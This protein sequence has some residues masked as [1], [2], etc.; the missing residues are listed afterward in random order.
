MEQEFIDLFSLKR[1]N[2]IKSTKTGEIYLNEKNECFFMESPI[3]AKQFC[4]LNEGTDLLEA[5]Y[6]KNIQVFVNTLYQQGVDAINIKLKNEKD[7]I[8]YKI[9]TEDLKKNGYCNH[10]VNQCLLQL[11]QTGYK[12]Y[13]R[14]LKDE[15]FLTPV[16]LIKR[17]EEQYPVIKYC[18]V[19]KDG[20]YYNILFSTLQEF[21]EWNEEQIS[22]YCP[23][24]V[25]ISKFERIRKN[26]S[27]LVNPLSRKIILDS[28]AIKVIKEKGA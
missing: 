12:K 19:K 23:L 17:K 25:D 5:K 3:E 26:N 2:I 27:V 18:A 28:T 15:Y 10:V 4:K 22:K 7:F 16:L 20:K 21:E 24:E 11:I 8:K 1:Y 14:L 13:L 6:Y 9:K